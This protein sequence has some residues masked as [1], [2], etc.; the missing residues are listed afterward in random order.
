MSHATLTVT[1]MLYLKVSSVAILI[2]TV[3]CVHVEEYPHFSVH[4]S[5]LSEG[6]I[7]LIREVS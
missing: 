2:E 3:E 7:I 5:K 4:N 1:A 6:A